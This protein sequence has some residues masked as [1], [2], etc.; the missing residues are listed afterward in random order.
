M[1]HHFARQLR[2]NQTDVERKL[3]YALRNRRFAGFKFRRQQPVG[4]YVADFV[5]FEKKL[6][7]ELDGSKHGR[8]QNTELHA[9]RTAR[10]QQDGFHVMR[11]WNVELIQSF[12][13]VLDAIWRELERTS[14]SPGLPRRS[15]A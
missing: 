12:D 9:R 2:R 6:I 7:I 11:F 8:D 5:C 1:K 14:P 13:S 15:R 4:P 3:W 10:L